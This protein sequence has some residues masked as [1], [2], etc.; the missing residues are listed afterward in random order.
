MALWQSPGTLPTWD[1]HQL[2]QPPPSCSPPESSPGSPPWLQGGT[3][4]SSDRRQRGL[5][6]SYPRGDRPHPKQVRFYNQPVHTCSTLP[7]KCTQET[8]QVAAASEQQ[9]GEAPTPVLPPADPAARRPRTYP[10]GAVHGKQRKPKADDGSDILHHWHLQIT[11][12]SASRP[13]DFPTATSYP[14]AAS[15]PH[16]LLPL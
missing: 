12:W 3:A 6:S 5:E 11:A 13:T 10:S 2:P 9:P 15:R 7:G 8:A 1:C 16:L 14:E 4:G